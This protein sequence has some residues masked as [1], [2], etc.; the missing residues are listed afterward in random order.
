MTLWQLQEMIDVLG[1]DFRVRFLVRNG[2]KVSSRP[3][4]GHPESVGSRT[5]TRILQDA[6]TLVAG[7]KRVD[8]P[9]WKD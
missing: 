1:P 6:A 3:A 4:L 2:R 7:R 9:A 8:C 5:N